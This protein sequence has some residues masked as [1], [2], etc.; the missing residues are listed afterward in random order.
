MTS[1]IT[2]NKIKCVSYKSNKIELFRNLENGIKRG[3]KPQEL[4]LTQQPE[5]GQLKL[6]WMWNAHCIIYST[7]FTGYQYI[8]D[9]YITPIIAIIGL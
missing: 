3:Q 5:S 1:G 2:P 7:S 9:N 6:Q 8:I 4:A